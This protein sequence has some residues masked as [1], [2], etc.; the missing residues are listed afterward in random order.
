M[1]FINLFQIQSLPISLTDLAHSRTN[2]ERL[3]NLHTVVESDQGCKSL[4]RKVFNIP[5]NPVRKGTMKVCWLCWGLGRP[6]EEG[7]RKGH[8]PPPEAGEDRFLHVR[9]T[10]LYNDMSQL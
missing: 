5:M 7:G 2:A 9:H 4:W 1:Y 10:L 8:Q 3:R 6:W